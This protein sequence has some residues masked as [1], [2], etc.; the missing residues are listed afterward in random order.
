MGY[1]RE[2]RKNK[3]KARFGTSLSQDILV[4]RFEGR[5][6][7]KAVSFELFSL[8]LAICAVPPLFKS[9]KGNSRK[10]IKSESEKRREVRWV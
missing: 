2:V 7:K 5:E 8:C 4:V 6:K 10:L 9:R 1:A 3:T